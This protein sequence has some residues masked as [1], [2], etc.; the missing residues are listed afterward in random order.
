MWEKIKEKT[1]KL[2]P[3]QVIVGYYFI[4]VTISAMLLSL[5]ISRKSDAP[6]SLIDAI[7]TAVSA[8][9]VTGLST[10]NISETFTTFGIF[11]LILVLQVGGIGIMTIGTFF[12]LIFRKRIGFRERRLIMIDQN[13]IN[14]AGLVKLLKQLVVIFIGIE[15]FG[16]LILGTYFL[17]YY[18]DWKDA[19]LQGI[20]AAVSAMTNAGFDITGASMKPF[21]TDYFVQFIIMMLIILGAI[22]FPVLVEVKNFL[23]HRGSTERPSFSLFTKITTFMYFILVVV[24]VFLFLLF[25]W[26]GIVKEHVWHESFLYSLFQSVSARSAGLVTIDITELSEATQFLLASLMFIG[27]S[28]SSVGGGIRTTTLALNILFLYNF[29]KGNPSIKLFH[30]EIYEQDVRKALLVFVFATMICSTSILF[31][32]FTEEH[33]LMAI[34]FEVMSAFGTSGM[35]MGITGDLSVFGKIVIMLLMFIG[36][37]GILSF[38]FMIG[39]KEKKENYHFPKERIIIG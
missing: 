25:E 20:F 23:F 16:S 33:S 29:A 6:W 3:A 24:G 9:S 35:S 38:V 34:I 32:T 11:I 22:G 15:I 26:N 7:F 5:P 8:V 37:V 4:A 13:Q 36:R 30:R 14:F 17:H 19:Y 18:S 2:T 31:L 27:A 39:G 28:P 12:W 1:N 21:A 10:V